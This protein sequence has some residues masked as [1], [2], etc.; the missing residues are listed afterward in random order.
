MLYPPPPPPRQY[1][2]PPAQFYPQR[3]PQYYVP[4]VGVEVARN[5]LLNF[6]DVIYVDED[7]KN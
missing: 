3:Q 7:G 5:S 1:Y 6:P 4:E 2:P